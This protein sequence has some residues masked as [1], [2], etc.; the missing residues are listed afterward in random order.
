MLLLLLLLLLLL[1][2]L[3]LLLHCRWRVRVLLSPFRLNLGLQLHRWL[4]MLLLLLLR[5]SW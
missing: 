5:G 4:L 3:P 2:L 1:P